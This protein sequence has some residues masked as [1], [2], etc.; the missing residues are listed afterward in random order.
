MDNV[1]LYVANQH[2]EPCLPGVDLAQLSSASVDCVVTY[3]DV[4]TGF[5]RCL[6]DIRRPCEQHP[7]VTHWLC[8]LEI[9]YLLWEMTDQCIVL[10]KT[11]EETIPTTYRY[12]SVLFLNA[13]QLAG[14]TGKVTSSPAPPGIF[15]EPTCVVY[16]PSNM[17]RD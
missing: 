5:R 11:N 14:L 16:L 1:L 9:E 10:F 4:N 3:M 6:C 2:I 8:K 13:Q 15:S 7:V 17:F 12:D